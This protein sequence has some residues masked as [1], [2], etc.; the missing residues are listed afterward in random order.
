MDVKSKL[1]EDQT[2]KI[3]IEF[4]KK[5][6]WEIES[7]CFGQE[8]GID[9][10]ARKKGKRLYIEVKGAKASEKAPTKKSD[11]FNSTQIRTHFGVAI[12]KAIKTQNRYPKDLVA[13]A[14]PDDDYIRKVLD[15]V[16]PAL[17]KLNII[18]FWVNAN[19]IVNQTF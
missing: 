18:H 16:V 1:T 14:Q 12:I 11:Y 7:C 2:I 3:L 5:D 9:I 10:V 15:G 4:L 8:R 19:G 6:F 13:I 17:K